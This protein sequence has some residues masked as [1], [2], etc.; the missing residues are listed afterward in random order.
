[1]PGA[2]SGV[3]NPKSFGKWRA[4]NMARAFSWTRTIPKLGEATCGMADL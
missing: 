1:M 3:A 4:R 2:A